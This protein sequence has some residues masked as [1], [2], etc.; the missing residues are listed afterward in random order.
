M[1]LTAV[2]A[3]AA[4]ARPRVL[5]VTTPG[6]TGVRLAAEQELR[7]RDWPSASTPA[8]ADLMLVA[9]LS[10][11]LGIAGQAVLTVAEPDLLAADRTQLA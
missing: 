1:G 4:A 11:V 2:L 3:R 10:L 5:L 8:G 6:G 9:A 7:S